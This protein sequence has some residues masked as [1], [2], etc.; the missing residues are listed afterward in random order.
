MWLIRRY[1][2]GFFQ[3]VL[4]WKIEQKLGAVNYKLETSCLRSHDI[5]LLFNFLDCLWVRVLWLL[6]L[7]I[8]HSK[9]KWLPGMVTEDYGS[10][11]YLYILSII[12]LYI[13][14]LRTIKNMPGSRVPFCTSKNVQMHWF[15]MHLTL[16][17][18]YILLW[19]LQYP[20]TSLNL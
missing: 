9:I 16:I 11:F 18:F 15:L 3:L 1:I 5:G 14:S 2:G 7:V 8:L 13:K 6:G 20:S 4:S 19:H 17:T 10:N 12:L